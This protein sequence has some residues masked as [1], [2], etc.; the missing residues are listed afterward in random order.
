MVFL[1]V[2]SFFLVVSSPSRAGN[3]DMVENRIDELD[4]LNKEAVTSFFL[5]GKG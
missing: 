1:I 2:L 4:K 5:S 3:R